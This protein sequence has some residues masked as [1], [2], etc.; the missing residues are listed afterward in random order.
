MRGSTFS[1][2]SR[3]LLVQIVLA[4]IIALTLAPAW[5]QSGNLAANAG[6]DE[7]GNR[8]GGLDADCPYGRRAWQSNT[9]AIFIDTTANA[10][11]NWRLTHRF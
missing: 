10:G 2:Y 8:I 9:D 6:S 3:L 4:S 1:F 7:T 11:G 5:A